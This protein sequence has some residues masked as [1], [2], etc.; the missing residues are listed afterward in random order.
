MLWRLGALVLLTS[1]LV[2]GASSVAYA[3]NEPAEPANLVAHAEISTE[4]SVANSAATETTE[5]TEPAT[6]EVSHNGTEARGDNISFAVV[7]FLRSNKGTNKTYN[8]HSFGYRYP[9]AGPNA[10]ALVATESAL[11]VYVPAATTQTLGLNFDEAA[12]QEAFKKLIEEIDE[13][14]ANGNLPLKT[15]TAPFI[16]T[17]EPSF[18]LD[19]CVY[20]FGVEVEPGY[21]YVSISA[22]TTTNDPDNA[23]LSTVAYYVNSGV[24]VPASDVVIDS[25]PQGVAA[26][27]EFF[28]GIDYRPFWV[29]LRTSLVAMIFVFVLGL[30]AAL[31][32]LRINERLRAVLDSI[33][34]IPMVLPPTVCGFLLLVAFG[35][36][37]GF[38]R[39][40]IDHG[41]VLVFTWPGAVI[42]AFVVA[43]PLMYR[44]ARGAFESLDPNLGDAART[45]GWSGARVFFKLTLPLAWPSIAAGTVLSFAR[46]LGEF[47]ATLFV[48]GNFAGITQTMPLA[49][50]FQWMGGHTEIATFWV[51]VVILISFLFIL[52][53]NWYAARVQRYRQAGADIDQDETRSPEARSSEARSSEAGVR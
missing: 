18:T 4:N 32:S 11:V 43:F 6:I 37:T 31:Y 15:L 30:A 23:S 39:W 21:Y 36:S 46:A 5:T 13:R 34:T 29:S 33:F 52:F 41:V 35:N 19:D 47:G 22:S 26:V 3:A 51:V 25:P 49:I 53:I 27:W 44:T 42:A 50:Y 12:T 16:F 8:N 14:V 17:S 40:L 38:G 48:A 9:V 10:F 20:Q 1:A 24:L 28:G 45:L 2:L 7:D